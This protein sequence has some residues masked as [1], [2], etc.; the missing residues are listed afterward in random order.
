MTPEQLDKLKAYVRKWRD[1]IGLQGWE[2]HVAQGDMEEEELTAETV[3]SRTKRIAL[4]TVNK[5][6]DDFTDNNL[7]Q[8]AFHE[9]W[10][11]KISRLRE[12]A[13]AMFSDNRV[14]SAEH[15]LIRTLENIMLR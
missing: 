12:M 15:A 1:T 14:D 3:Y 11:M 6:V 2:I 8:I 9:V 10:H 4:L 13:S 7:E 5:T